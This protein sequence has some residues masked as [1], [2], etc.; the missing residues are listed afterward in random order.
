M[1][2][3]SVETNHGVIASY[4]ERHNVRYKITAAK[5]ATLMFF[6]DEQIREAIEKGEENAALMIEA[7]KASIERQSVTNS[8]RGPIYVVIVGAIIAFVM[9]FVGGQISSSRDRSLET[10]KAQAALVE[11]AIGVTA[12]ETRKNLEFLVATNLI[13]D[14]VV[15]LNKLAAAL[16]TSS[17]VPI[18]TA[19]VL[20]PEVPSQPL[21]GDF[22]V[23]LGSDNSLADA[24]ETVLAYYADRST[25]LIK[26]RGVYRIAQTANSSAE[27]EDIIS[28]LPEAVQKWG[29]Y[30]VSRS[31]WCPESLQSEEDP[32]LIQC[33]PA[34]D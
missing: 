3:P 16:E 1:H 6:K 9:E 19:P 17:D 23:L 26:R 18:R 30:T 5:K 11:N 29:P 20:A 13:T 25:I 32:E 28:N 27:A 4:C 21:P 33:L 12:E 10:F 24:R 15:D 8:F 7:N 31:S 34:E 2:E 14:E 22:L